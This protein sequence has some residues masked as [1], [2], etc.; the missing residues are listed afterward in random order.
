MQSKLSVCADCEASTT[1]MHQMPAVATEGLPRL[2]S[3]LR[4]CMFPSVVQAKTMDRFRAVLTDMM[5]RQGPWPRWLN[6]LHLSPKSCHQPWTLLEKAVDIDD[7]AA[8]QEL[9]RVGA[10]A[11]LCLPLLDGG[12]PRLLHRAMRASSVTHHSVLPPT[13]RCLLEAGAQLPDDMKECDERREQVQQIMR[14]GTFPF[15]RTFLS[16]HSLSG[17]GVVES[18][19]NVM[20]AAVDAVHS[21]LTDIDLP[22]ELARLV[23][24]YYCDVE[25]FVRFLRSRT[26]RDAQLLRESAING[27]DVRIGHT[28]RQIATLQED[29]RRLEQ[30][31]DKLFTESQLLQSWSQAV[32]ATPY[33]AHGEVGAGAS[34]RARD[35]YQS[36]CAMRAMRTCTRYKCS[37]VRSGDESDNDDDDDG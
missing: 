23:V 20:T 19:A 29:V 4:Y 8:V 27:A 13:L 17:R 14:H 3:P 10:D 1:P 18:Y 31:R 26:E 37:R 30:E 25:A 35:L 7:T 34:A 21:L 28:L 2:S 33:F 5:T 32:A 15:W 22:F 9:I 6:T 16:P 36:D 24:N 11:N 12:T